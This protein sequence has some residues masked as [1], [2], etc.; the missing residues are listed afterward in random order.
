MDQ[1]CIRCKSVVN[2]G[3]KT[4]EPCRIYYKAH[5]KA[6]REK[7]KESIAARTKEWKE[8]NREKVLAYAREYN[9]KYTETGKRA[10]KS[11]EF[12]DRIKQAN[13]TGD[14]KLCTACGK[15]NTSDYKYCDA[16]REYHKQH[17]H[18]E[19]YKTRRREYDLSRTE[20]NAK[21]KAEWYSK[22]RLDKQR[23]KLDMYK[24]GAK[25]REIAWNLSDVEANVIIHQI[26][27]Y[28]G[29]EPSEELNGIDRKD[30]NKGYSLDNVV[31]CCTKCNYMKNDRSESEFID[32]CE[33]LGVVNGLGGVQRSYNLFKT[34]SDPR[35]YYYK[36]NAKARE[37]QFDLT[38]DEF[39]DL[40][41][42]NC[43]YCKRS[44]ANGIDRVNNSLGYVLENC[45]S[46]CATCNI[47]KSDM[48]ED[49]FL[50]HCKKI[51]IHSSP[52]LPV[53][54]HTD[55]ESVNS[56]LASL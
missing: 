33:H 55:V 8:Q 32:I 19:E 53:L 23:Y 4:C 36:R 37:L 31:P 10:Q 38:D 13:E 25:E 50:A 28:C 15:E 17:A 48:S 3:Y 51:T 35:I 40:I 16:C 14:V 46:C 24:R 11:K 43:R 2:D 12:R 44:N 27:H 20:E 47:M 18:T 34:A 41:R 52:K 21:L 22:Y 9:K 1:L 29:E 30:S 39:D 6:S 42:S 26:C 5:Q 49:V 54:T 7:H 45:A 56:L